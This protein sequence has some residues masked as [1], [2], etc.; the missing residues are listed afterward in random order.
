MAKITLCGLT[1]ES[2]HPIS[3][4]HVFVLMGL[5]VLAAVLRF[6][7][8]DAQSLW[9]DEG[10]SARIAERSVQLIIEGA[11]GDIH[12][13]LY[14]LSLKVW[15]G[16]FGSSEA[17]LRAFS[18]LC[19]VLTVGLTYLIGR[20]WFNPRSATLA[21]F[22]VALSP[23]GVYYSQETRMYALLALAAAASTWALSPL[24]MGQSWPKARATIYTLATAIGLYTQY[25]YPFVM[26]AQGLCFVL[27][28]KPIQSQ[29]PDRFIGIIPYII[30]N[31]IALAVFAPWLPIA[32][33]QIRGWTVAPQDYA[34]WP[35]VLDCLRWIS[36]GRTLPQAEAALPM[37]VF[38]AF[39]LIAL[40][41]AQSA[42]RPLMPWLTLILFALPVTLLFAFKLYRD[43]YL[44][45]LLVCVP[46]MALLI[47]HGV[48]QIVDLVT[49]KVWEVESAKLKV[50]STL[51]AFA[52]L[53]FTLLSFASLWNLYFNP[54]DARDDYRGIA[55]QLATDSRQDDAILF[56]APNQWEVFT[57][58]WP[59]VSKT[60]PLTYR[61]LSET[62]VDQQLH[63][64]TDKRQRLF[65]LYYAEREADQNGWYERWLNVHTYKAD[66][67]WVGNIRLAVYRT[68]ITLTKV[69]QANAVFG[70]Q[71]QLEQAALPAGL[72]EGAQAGDVLPFALRW[73][74]LAKIEQPYK[75]FVHIG[76]ANSAPVAQNDGE[77]VVGSRPTQ[78]WVLDERVEDRRAV[79]I[80]PG[81]PPGTYS[82]WVGLYDAVTGD[83]LK[84]DNGA[85]QVELG[86]VTI[87]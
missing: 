27:A 82:I 83:R 1:I 56:L 28:I 53:L 65:V 80:K 15:R 81:T 42:P 23:F 70:G 45:F 79:W 20:E 66:Q 5:L 63:E 39:M 64:I 16:T 30:T 22:I 13:P 37:L 17:A 25:A 48:A 7:R 73:R 55:R 68:P 6:Y 11:A 33:R 18:A 74:A 46:P 29:R 19:G 72:Q 36:V 54:S 32:I 31:L 71:I 69:T 60:F 78:S 51:S 41:R 10:N 2:V 52:F 50:Q 4:R 87:H 76:A 21:G 12:P 8:I 77:P 61:P 14:Y 49:C 40:L 26:L 84:L 3:R 38:A 58:Y 62:T 24:L 47:G 59:D 75:V 44:K 34:L 67:Q 57:Y 9:Y 43:A 35:A 85:D 86:S